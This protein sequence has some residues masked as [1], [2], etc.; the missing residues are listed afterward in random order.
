MNPNQQTIEA[1]DKQAKAYQRIF[2]DLHL[3]DET[4]EAFCEL[5]KPNARVLE[6]G[7]GPGNI[8][9]YVLNKR[10]DLQ[11]QATD[12]APAMVDLAQKNNP[13][14]T[15]SLLDVR[16]LKNLKATYDGLI[17]GFCL[18]YLNQEDAVKLIGNSAK[19]L[20]E[21]GIF[22]LST[23]AGDYSQSKIQTSSNGQYQ[24]WVYYYPA[25]TLGKFLQK[26]SFE[27]VR[28][29]QIPYSKTDGTTETHL[30]FICRKN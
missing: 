9:R 24:S 13:A 30:I 15:C 23:I 26:A 17:C 21:G 20:S 4:Y 29:F 12:A 6:L 28:Q 27:V 22:Y 19:I 5:V 10:P 18:P 3:Y 11:L 1:F 25:E 14:A 2:M 8:T 16:E 7:C